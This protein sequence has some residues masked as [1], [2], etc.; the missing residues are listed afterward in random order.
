MPHIKREHNRIFYSSILHQFVLFYRSETNSIELLWSHC[1]IQCIVWGIT[2]FLS[3]YRKRCFFG[4]S[5]VFFL[6]FI[7]CMR[8]CGQWVQLSNSYSNSNIHSQNDKVGRTQTHIRLLMT[9]YT[10]MLHIYVAKILKLFIFVNKL[11]HGIYFPVL[12]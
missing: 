1:V 11:Y 6:S 7:S 12:V 5:L 4:V 9:L 10:W 8:A 3:Q 2:S